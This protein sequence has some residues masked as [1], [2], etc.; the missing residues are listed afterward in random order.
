MKYV[1][2]FVLFCLAFTSNNALAFEA[3]INDSQVPYEI[4]DASITVSDGKTYV[5]R[6]EDY[7][8]MYE[9]VA[10]EEFDLRISLE[11]LPLNE[12]EENPTIIVVREQFRGGVEEVMRVTGTDARWEEYYNHTLATTLFRSQLL[13]RSLE[14]GTY[15]VEVSSPNNRTR[16]LLTIGSENIG[17]GYW[18]TLGSIREVHGFFGFSGLK[19]LF[20]T[21]IYLPLL[22]ILILIT[23]FLEYRRRTRRTGV[24]Y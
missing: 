2:G 10:S 21:Y 11:H 5:G 17:S 4:S 8:E 7:P 6:L 22:V 23:L 20:S 1:L 3:V 19:I 15:R 24:A 14:A 18:G 16:Y 13:E 12:N 9:I